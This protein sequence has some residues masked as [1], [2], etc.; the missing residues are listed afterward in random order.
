MTKATLMKADIKL[1]LADSFRG[2]VHC[3]HS[4]KEGSVQADM[5]LS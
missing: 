1:G 2:S 4:G 5:E 3:H